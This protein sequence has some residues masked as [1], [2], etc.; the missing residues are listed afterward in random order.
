MIGSY[1]ILGGLDE[2]QET[3][4]VHRKD[5]LFVSGG[6]GHGRVRLLH[7]TIEYGAFRLNPKCVIPTAIKLTLHSINVADL[8]RWFDLSIFAELRQSRTKVL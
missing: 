1:F 7:E 5:E 8:H 4:N 3:L 6:I 2:L